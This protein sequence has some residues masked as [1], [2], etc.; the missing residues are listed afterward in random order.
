MFLWAQKFSNLDKVTVRSAKSFQQYRRIFVKILHHNKCELY[1][2]SG[3]LGAERQAQKE[4]HR[5]NRQR[6][7]RGNLEEHRGPTGRPCRASL[8][9]KKGRRQACLCNSSLAAGSG[10]TLDQGGDIPRTPLTDVSWLGTL[11]VI[12]SHH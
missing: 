10:P 3:G 1:C 4:R 8:Q 9:I 12:E 2:F 7:G 5:R 6:E 11:P